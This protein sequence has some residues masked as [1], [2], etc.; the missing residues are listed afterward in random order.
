MAHKEQ[1]QAPKVTSAVRLR[2]FDRQAEIEM[3]F[4][5]HVLFTVKEMEMIVYALGWWE[6]WKTGYSSGKMSM[7]ME[8]K[9]S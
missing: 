3:L 2:Y 5:Q 7:C 8:G 9:L 6:R 1:L 4:I